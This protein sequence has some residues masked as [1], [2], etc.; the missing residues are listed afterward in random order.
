MAEKKLCDNC[1]AEIPPGA[2]VCPECGWL[3]SVVSAEERDKKLKELAAILEI[4]ES[5]EEPEHKVSESPLTAQRENGKVGLTNGRVNGLNARE[6]FINGRRNKVQ[7]M[8][9]QQ[10]QRAIVAIIAVF[11]II[12]GSVII[13]FAMQRETGKIQ[14][15][16]NFG[17]WTDVPKTAVVS[18]VEKE[19]IAPSELAVYDEPT[20][21]SF[22][23]KVRGKMLAGNEE[24]RITDG[25]YILL[26][27][28]ANKYTGYSMLGYGFDFRISVFG[29]GGYVQSASI[30]EFKGTDQVNW[31]AW[32]QVSQVKSACGARELEIQADKKVVNPGSNY[33]AILIMKSWDGITSEPFVF[34]PGGGYLE[35]RVLPQADEILNESAVFMKIE[36]LAKGNDA[37]MN[38]VSFQIMGNARNYTLELSDGENILGSTDVGI[39]ANSVTIN[40]NNYKLVRD[41]IVTLLVSANLTGV[42]DGCSAGVSPTIG[43]RGNVPAVIRYAYQHEKNFVGYY[44]EVSAIP[45]I[46]GAFGEWKNVVQD[47]NR[48]GN[49][50]VDISEYAMTTGDMLSVYV[51]VA[52]RIFNGT[53]LPESTPIIG[54]GGGQATEKPRITGEDTMY[55]Y[56]YTVLSAN[57]DY[58][59]EIRGINNEIKSAVFYSNSNGT[60]VQMQVINAKNSFW[61]VEAEIPNVVRSTFF[62]IEIEFHSWNGSDAN[63]V[64]LSSVGENSGIIQCVPAFVIAGII[65]IIYR[66]RKLCDID[67]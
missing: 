55:V 21:L 62:Y 59:I 12:V 54:Q 33:T 57:P 60:W 43:L 53:L 49:P 15:D 40:L 45:V 17:D 18:G 6:G 51:G 24:K 64:I 67:D 19:N 65:I 16:G 31:S 11:L 8:K 39:D 56:L 3:I 30:Y 20:G 38:D 44:K 52:G 50:D 22:Y 1:G 42:C 35:A 46:D 28:D 4:E 41:R 27:T 34:S 58:M 25:C 26:D 2:T 36:L 23:I 48:I 29:V 5:R 13:Y 47:N 66:R 63:R 7:V 9:T 61:Q 32:T 14:V 10:R 37:I